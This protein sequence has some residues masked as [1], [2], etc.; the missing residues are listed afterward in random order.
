VN[1][2]QIEDTNKIVILLGVFYN[3]LKTRSAKITTTNCMN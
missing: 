2:P 3:K 1:Q